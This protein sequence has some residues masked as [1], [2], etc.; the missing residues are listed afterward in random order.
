MINGHSAC[1]R[2]CSVLFAAFVIGFALSGAK[3][4]AIS[5]SDFDYRNT[6]SGLPYR[7]YAPMGLEP[8]E[9]IPLILFLHGAGEKGTNNTSQ[10]ANRANGAFNLIEDPAR[11]AYMM[12]PQTPTGWASATIA[13]AVM[14]EVSKLLVETP[15]IDPNRVYITGLSMGGEGT[16][17]FMNRFPHVFAGGIPI[18]GVTTISH[19]GTISHIPTWAYHNDGDGVI[20]VSHSRTMVARL[21]RLGSPVIYSE[22]VSNSHNSWT[23]A[24]TNPTTRAWIFSQ[25]KGQ[26]ISSVPALA[27]PVPQLADTERIICQSETSA[28][29]L[30]SPSLGHN[31]TEITWQNYVAANGTQRGAGSF[32]ND[33]ETWSAQIPNLVIGENRIIVIATGSDY[34]PSRNGKTTV[35]TSF[36]VERT[37]VGNDTFSP[38]IFVFSPESFSQ[39]AADVS[40][41]SLAGVARDGG[42]LMGVT[43]ENHRGGSGVA[44]GGE[45]WFITEVPLEPGSNVILLKAT[46]A[47]GNDSRQEIVV[48]RGAPT[49]FPPSVSAGPDRWTTLGTKVQLLGDASDD[50]GS[51]SLL[52]SVISGPGGV[53]FQSSSAAK[54]WATFRIPGVY[55]LKLTATDGE[56]TRSDTVRVRV[57]NAFS[58]LWQ[59]D[60]GSLIMNEG[61]NIV[62]DMFNLSRSDA[63][64]SEGIQTGVG[65]NLSLSFDGTWFSTVPGVTLYPSNVA[66]DSLFVRN[67]GRGAIT[68]T[69]FDPDVSYRV[70]V[71]GSQ[72]NIPPSG[73]MTA[74]YAIGVEFHTLDAEENGDQLAIFPNIKP[75]A[76]GDFQ[77]QMRTL[78][79]TTPSIAHLNA[80]QIERLNVVYEHSNYHAW[81]LSHGFP[82]SESGQGMPTSLPSK[83]AI[84]NLIKYALGLNPHEAG[85]HGKISS[86]ILRD[87]TLPAPVE[88]MSLSATLP[89]PMPADLL[90]LPEASP[91]LDAWPDS[92]IEVSRTFNAWNGTQTITWRDPTPLTNSSR[93]F[94]R[95]RVE[96]ID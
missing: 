59:F 90:L 54:A 81:A 66:R 61:W 20:P 96:L 34:D 13:D 41:V 44:T 27:I 79:F 24:Y 42:S 28:P 12:A 50:D 15:E 71:F 37:D 33:G 32:V 1:W 25:V 30:I 83:D 85:I 78:A 76:S 38:R 75:N 19:A 80:V 8:D 65:Y 92:L 74:R 39:V 69:G 26:F 29:L 67:T 16:W 53:D 3:S 2:K 9:K 58:T 73:D 40:A 49:N 60:F 51:P 6:Q 62:G 22:F 35:T 5:A 72:R 68:F 36:T 23:A 10:I 43:W 4:F 57:S 95:L 70:T 46:D 21:Q 48:I 56:W 18:C 55:F 47:A 94:L 91:N 84:P 77:L 82:S 31:P 86:G 64:D 14:D 87:T 7:W 17:Y 93:R 45:E 88:Y 89:D 52:W 11:K 63:I